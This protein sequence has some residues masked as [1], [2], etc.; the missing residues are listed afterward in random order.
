MWLNEIR[1][2]FKKYDEK[3]ITEARLLLS[4][5]LDKYKRMPFN[6]LSKLIKKVNCYDVVGKSGTTYQIEIWVTFENHQKSILFCLSIDG[7][8]ISSSKPISDTFTRHKQ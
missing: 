6:E 1:D 2:L 5:E 7:G 3:D 4:E 8:M